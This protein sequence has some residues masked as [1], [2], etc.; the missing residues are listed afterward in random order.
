M[1]I[2][3]R[4]IIIYII[5]A[6]N[7]IYHTLHLM[8][9]ICMSVVNIYIVNIIIVGRF[10]NMGISAAMWRVPNEMWRRINGQSNRR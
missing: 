3:L 10:L 5:Y 9:I 7:V 2:L 8:K 1:I 6:I 4:L